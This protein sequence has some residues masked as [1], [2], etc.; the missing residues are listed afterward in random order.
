MNSHYNLQ[1]QSLTNSLSP[2]SLTCILIT[3]NLLSINTEQEEGEDH[4]EKVEEEEDSN[5]KKIWRRFT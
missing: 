4:E 2:T 5:R 1:S 3:R